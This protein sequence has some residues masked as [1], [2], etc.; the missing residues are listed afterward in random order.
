MRRFNLDRR[1]KPANEMASQSY[2]DQLTHAT[3]FTLGAPSGHYIF[4]MYKPEPAV[5]NVEAVL[6]LT[7]RTT[8]KDTTEFAKILE[9]GLIDGGQKSEESPFLDG[10]SDR[11]ELFLGLS[12]PELGPA[13]E[14]IAVHH[15]GIPG[16]QFAFEDPLVKFDG[17]QVIELRMVRVGGEGEIFVNGRRILY[18]PIDLK[19]ADLGFMF[20]IVG[21]TA[22][23]KQLQISEL[24]PKTTV[25]QAADGGLVEAHRRESS[26]RRDPLR[27]RRRQV[28]RRLLDQPVGLDRL[29]RAD[30]Q[31]RQV[32]SRHDHRLRKGKRRQRIRTIRRPGK[33]GKADRQ[34]QRHQRLDHFQPRKTRHD[35]N[36]Q[37]R[38]NHDQR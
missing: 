17:T 36:P 15:S 21:M 22:D 26:R 18:A 3:P 19:N 35:R 1:F 32:R 10:P 28:V 5:R 16:I 24:L 8:D 25:H 2:G 11:A 30:R 9:V 38:P 29:G 14:T 20:K 33:N 7:L 37:T 12:S 27:D 31:A 23:F 13:G 4:L 6:K 34:G